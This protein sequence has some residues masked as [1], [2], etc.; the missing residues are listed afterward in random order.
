MVSS[1]ATRDAAVDSQATPE[2]LSGRPLVRLGGFTLLIGAVLYWLGEAGWFFWVRD[3]EDPRGYP[4]PTATYLWLVLLVGFTAI[5]LG[6]PGLHLIQARRAK[7]F[8]TVAFVVLFAGT[9]LMLGIINFGAFYQAVAFDLLKAAEAAG[10]NVDQ[11]ALPAVAA[12]P[13]I[14][15]LAGYGVHMVGWVLFGIA[16]LRA[17]VLPRWPVVVAMLGSILMFPFVG[18][19][20]LVMQIGMAWLGVVMIRLE[21]RTRSLAPA[22]A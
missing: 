4:Q 15:W 6:L 5:L 12:M 19:G 22:A 21:R 1:N 3:A 13:D 10:V 18:L 16:A 20:P 11:V 2:P 9:V 7:A 14:G 17:R 8:G